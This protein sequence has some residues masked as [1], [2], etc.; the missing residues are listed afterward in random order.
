[1]MS[2]SAGSGWA[3]RQVPNPATRAS[4]RAEAASPCP[5]R[6]TGNAT[7][8]IVRSVRPEGPTT[9]ASWSSGVPIQTWP[10]IAQGKPVRITPRTHSSAVKATTKPSAGHRAL[11]L[12]AA[13]AAQNSPSPADRKTTA[14]GA[15]QPWRAMSIRKGSMIHDSASAKWPVPA[16]RPMRKA[17]PPVS[18]RPITQISPASATSVRP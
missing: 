6:A 18:A 16:A 10:T 3:S 12:I 11:V 13:A 4:M 7:A 15:I 8:S 17:A 9:E 14:K 5:R 2:R 1:M